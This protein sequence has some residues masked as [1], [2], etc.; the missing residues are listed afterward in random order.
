MNSLF[1]YINFKKDDGEEL[2][3][4]ETIKVM[5]E[6]SQLMVAITSCLN[7]M[8]LDCF[9]KEVKFLGKDA[10]EYNKF[11]QAIEYIEGAGESI[12][13]RNKEAIE[14]LESMRLT[15]KAILRSGLAKA[16]RSRSWWMFVRILGLDIL[17]YTSLFFIFLLTVG[18]VV[19]LEKFN[20]FSF[21]E[22]KNI[23]VYERFLIIIPLVFFSWFVSK[24]SQFLYQVREE[25]LYKQTSALAYEAYKSEAEKNE[26]M[27][28]RLLEVTI[29]N[30]ARS[31]LERLDKNI[32]HAPYNHIINKL[33]TNK[34]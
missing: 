34:E 5:A 30:L 23:E 27:L 28:D 9:F 12:C 33:N 29:D 16:F 14:I 24:R 3:E 1:Y 2:T 26:A 19:N 6:I 22:L 20:L 13:A 21:L 18:V 10:S 7:N 11:L 31:P 25:Y 4:N 8:K 32:D 15:K 17:N